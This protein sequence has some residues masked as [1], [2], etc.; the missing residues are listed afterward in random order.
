[1]LIRAVERMNRKT[2]MSCVCLRAGGVKLASWLVSLL[3]LMGGDLGAL[4][5]VSCLHEGEAL[6]CGPFQPM[7]SICRF[8]VFSG[9]DFP[10]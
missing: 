2:S 4:E 8:L 10:S 3:A 1:M 5:K 9:G 6:F 7:I